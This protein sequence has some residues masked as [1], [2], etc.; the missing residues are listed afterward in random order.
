MGNN[1]LY[2]VSSINFNLFDFMQTL[3]WP[4]NNKSAKN[5]SNMELEIFEQTN[6]IKNLIEKYITK[7]NYI[8]INLPL[9]IKKVFLI[10][11]GSSYHCAYIAA[12]MLKES[13]NCDAEAIYASEFSINP[14]NQV[15]ETTLYIFIS[16]SGETSDTLQALKEIARKT[17]NILCVTNNKDST[18]WQLS[19]YK[20]LTHA[21]KEKSIAS[22]KA[23]SAQ[24]FCLYLIVLKILYSKNIDIT[25]DL[26]QIHNLPTHISNVLDSAKNIKK[27]AKK[28]SEFD[29]ISIL[30]SKYFY[31]LAK[32]G[33]LKI[34]ETSYINTCAYPH[35]EF[36]HGHVAILNKK[37]AII[38]IMDELHKNQMLKNLKS[39]R[40]DYKPYLVSIFNYETIDENYSLSN[41]NIKIPTD[42]NVFAIFGTLITLQLLALEIA[43]VLKKNIDKPTGL[44]KV[45]IN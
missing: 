41:H 37:A 25:A 10:A 40:N 14:H 18:L 33:A 22:T 32:E 21:G 4:M 1:Y 9:I 8:L 35:G 43:K 34:K 38:S 17:D 12:E 15:D 16:Q 36:M 2:R 3:Y 42:T 45:V 29:N 5:K 19:S 31:A 28:L 20:V 39:I 30:G 44:K 24:L 26:A 7:E 11:S 6:I 13:V 23:M 27:I